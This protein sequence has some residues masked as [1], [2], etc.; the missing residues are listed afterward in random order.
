MKQ[1]IVTIDTDGK[2]VVETAG[3]KGKACSLDSKALEEALGVSTKD[4]KRP[5][6]FQDRVNSQNVGG[7]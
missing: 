2:C 5:E 6:Y 1:I 7:S 3:Y 4:V